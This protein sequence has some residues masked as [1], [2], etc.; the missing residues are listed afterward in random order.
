MSKKAWI[1]VLAAVG[2]GLAVVL[3][4]A[5]NSQTVAEKQYCS[6]LESLQ[7]EVSTL[8]NLDPSTTSKETL[9]T[10]FDAIQTDW[11][12]VKSAAQNVANLDE[13]SLDDAWNNFE[14]AFKNIPS[15][16]SVSDA[17]SDVKTQADALQSAIKSTESSVDCSSS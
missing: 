7:S 4:I 5:S 10:T 17:Q 15:D 1:I 6:A 3:G 12:D 11:G 13:N 14:S 8:Q 2:V 16:A 9:Q